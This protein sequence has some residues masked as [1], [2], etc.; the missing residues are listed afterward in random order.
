MSQR[1]IHF[2]NDWISDA[3]D[4][5]PEAPDHRPGVAL[6]EWVMQLVADAAI[7]GISRNEIEEGVG[8]LASY[9]VACLAESAERRGERR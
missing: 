6:N 9:I 8:D 3:I 1:G 2:T 5:L 7:E 4:H